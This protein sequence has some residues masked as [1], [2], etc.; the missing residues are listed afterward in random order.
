[1]SKRTRIVV[2]TDGEVDPFTVTATQGAA[3]AV[4]IDTGFTAEETRERGLQVSMGTYAMADIT[5]GPVSLQPGIRFNAYTVDSRAWAAIDPR[6]AL[7]WQI[8]DRW[9]FRAGV[10][11]FT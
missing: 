3:G 8:A 6:F 7:R 9:A 5:L 1:L 4:G 11:L 10:G 2:G